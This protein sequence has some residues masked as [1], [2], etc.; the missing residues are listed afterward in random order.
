MT[1]RFLRAFSIISTLVLGG[2]TLAQEPQQGGTLNVGIV[3]DPVTLDPTFMASFFEL[4][5]QYLIHEPLLHLTADLEIEPGLAESYKVEGDV[6]YTFTLRERLTFHD[7]TPLDAEAVK[8]NFDRMLDPE[9]GSPRLSEL[10]PVESVEITGPLEFT[11]T[12]TEPYA[13]FLSVLTNRAGMM[14]SP[15]ALEELGEDFANQAVG[16]GPFRV[17]SWLKNSELVLERF[18][19]YWREGQPHL[20][21][22]VLRPLADETVRLTNLR[23]GSLQLINDV[24]AQNIASL[25]SNN[26]LQLFERPGLGF[27]DI[28]LNTTRPPFDDVRVR[29]ALWY[30]IDPNVIQQVVFF[31]TGQVAYGPIPPSISWAYDP[32]F[33]PYQRDVERAR[34]LLD[35]AGLDGVPFTI[36]VTN[37]PVQVRIAEIV[38]AQAA[39]AGF[40]IDIRQIDS[41]SL[42][43]VLVERDFDA[44]WAPWSGRPDPDGNMFNY[45]TVDGPNNFAGYENDEL[46]ELLREARGTLDQTVRAELYQKAQQIVAEAAPL[47]FFHHDASLQAATSQVEG[48]QQWPD[49]AFHLEG[50]SLSQ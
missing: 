21:G 5:A 3:S 36:T 44:S 32:S 30:A 45:F 22:V 13:P 48:Y 12:L 17:A 16:A 26:N 2:T 47:I 31:G 14:V 39:E 11:I 9:A 8:A 10:G 42:I 19:G 24:P 50:V 49:G 18:D 37:S 35:E 29:Q 28:A 7:G 41:T 1:W 15:T 33:Q 40:E 6:V 34:S 27:N 23:S 4:S 20:D 43:S 38:Q 25:Q 46:D